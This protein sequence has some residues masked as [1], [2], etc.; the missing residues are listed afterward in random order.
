M[1]KVFVRNFVLFMLLL[2]VCSSVLIY[3]F[4]QGDRE[5]DKIDGWVLHTHEVITEAE[6]ISSRVRAMLAAQRG[7]LLTANADFLEE[8]Q[9]KKAEVSDHIATIKELTANNI[10]QQSRLADMHSTYLQFAEKLEERAQ[11][12]T[13]EADTKILSDVKEVDYLKNQIININRKVLD[14]EYDLLNQRVKALDAKKSQY[15]TSLIAGVIIGSILLLLFNSFLFSAQKKRSR[16]EATLKDSEDRFRLASEGTSDGIF[17]WDIKTDQVYYSAQ[18]FHML[19]YDKKSKHGTSKDFTDLIHPEDK[20]SVW[21]NVQLYLEGNL[22]EYN[23]EF[24]LKHKS[25]HWIWVQSRA[26]ALYDKNNKPYRMVGAHTDISHL[27]R[28]QEKLAEE[29]KQ[30]EAANIAKGDF[31]A[32]MSHEIRTPLTAISGIAEI[33]SR[34]QSNLD[35]KQRKLIQ[36]LNSSTS[37]LKDLV[38]DILD[39]SKIESGELE[40]D[41]QVFSLEHL[42]AEVISMMAVRANEKVVSFVFDDSQ[43]KGNDFYGDDHRLRQIIVNLIGNALKFTDS[44]GAV[45]VEA[46]YEDREDQEYL[47]VN[48][49]DTGIGIEPQNFDAIFDRFKQADSSVSRRFGGTGLGLPISKNLAQLMGG[50]IFLSS[51]VGKGSTFSLLL[52]VKL[53]D[54]KSNKDSLKEK[55]QNKKL[56]EKIQSSLNETTK[57]LIVEDYEG[58]V[59]VIEYML[60]ELNID[61]D[62]AENGAIALEIWKKGH[63][64][65]ILMDVQMPEMDG[66]TATQEIRKYEKKE[67][68]NPVPIIGM[69]AHALVGDKDKCIESGMDSYLPKPIVESHF[70]REVYKYLK[71]KKKAA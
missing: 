29:K 23:K 22:S 59:T 64:D 67:N 60:D 26:K 12:V 71:N 56:S 13:R 47:R 62:V 5:L 37:S 25:G 51:Q 45:S 58:N 17:D 57:A 42:F 50:D 69:T 52:P 9:A 63:Y 39:F 35:Q 15:L 4:I 36:T 46:L 27:K 43:V 21:E 30:A 6:K 7:Y 54:S 40:L 41:E 66:F 32:H 8:Y 3:R 53:E 11:A 28:E 38:N 10:S 33:F 2:A 19:G 31:L 16:A 55:N 44:G 70:K 68:L 61:Y 18:Y 48:V 14:E 49:S 1:D 24:R 65:F 34:N 20:D